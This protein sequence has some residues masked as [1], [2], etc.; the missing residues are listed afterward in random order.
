MT[1]KDSLRVRQRKQY[2]ASREVDHT[3]EDTLNLPTTSG[4]SRR[5]H[6]R[7]QAACRGDFGPHWFPDPR[8]QTGPYFAEC[9]ARCIAVCETCPVKTECLDMALS[10]GHLYGIFAGTTP[11][12]RKEINRGL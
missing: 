10:E 2:L 4:T 11:A 7:T 9:L 12:Q 6:W 8:N 5:E 1:S 3:A